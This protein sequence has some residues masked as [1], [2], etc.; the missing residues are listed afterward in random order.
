MVIENCRK[1]GQANYLNSSIA[2]RVQLGKTAC[3]LAIDLSSAQGLA[4]FENEFSHLNLGFESE[5]SRT[6]TELVPFVNTPQ[7]D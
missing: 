3:L 7:S 1:T 2:E 5:E 6:S 4:E